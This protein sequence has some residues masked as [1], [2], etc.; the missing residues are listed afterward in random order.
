MKPVSD[1]IRARRGARM[2]ARRRQMGISQGEIGNELE[3]SGAGYG[4]Y[5]RG[6]NGIDIDH[7]PTIARHLD[8]PIKWFFEE[9]GAAWASGPD[10]P[11]VVQRISDALPG[12]PDREWLASIAEALSQIP[13]DRRR[14][15]E[16]R[17]SIYLQGLVDAARDPS[18]T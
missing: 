11:A 5:E 13:T 6:I 17:V 16:E 7:L 18:S 14:V 2:F 15:I 9:H 1:T 10:V 12:G 3:M 4:M 8:V